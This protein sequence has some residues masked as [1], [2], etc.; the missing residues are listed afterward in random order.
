M[1]AATPEL[2]ETGGTWLVSGS[3]SERVVSFTERLEIE[4]RPVVR[5]DEAPVLPER[6]NSLWHGI[7]DKGPPNRPAF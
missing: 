2:P 3:A 4:G 6:P 7:R 5:S 1:K